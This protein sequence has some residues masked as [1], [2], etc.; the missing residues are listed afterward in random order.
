MRRQPVRIRPRLRT[1]RESGW[2][3]I[4]KMTSGKRIAVWDGWRGI[5][6]LLVLIGHFTFSSWIWEER[7]GVD[8]FFVLSG[9]L[10]SNILFVERM[11][12]SDFYIRRFSRVIPALV[13]FLLAAF[14]VSL[15]L[16]YDFK[17]S[18][19]LASLFFVRTY[20]PTDPEYF[21]TQLPTG[22]LWSLNVEEHAYIIMSLISIILISRAK[23]ALVLIAIYV[24]SVIVNFYNYVNLPALEF[25]YSLIR[26]ESAIGFI[27]FSA[28]YTLFRIKY[29]IQIHP[30]LPLLLFVL[31]LAC[32]MRAVPIWLTFLVSPV[33]LGIA[34]NHL[35][36]AAKSLQHLLMFKPLRWLGILSYSIYLWQQIFYKLYYAL[37]GGAFTGFVLSIVAGAG[38]FYIVE[39]PLRNA[40]NR[41]WSK[42]PSYRRKATA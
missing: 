42:A 1:S 13:V 33:F 15:L 5:A 11:H 25:E 30:Q 6:I 21:S 41:R 35:V 28:A 40:I 18:E 17:T 29:S 9:M 24:A 12:L 20:F 7:F 3:C 19:F 22:H 34:V 8:V 4:F 26:T 37:P 39:T 23:V 36:D 32:Y 14:A 10:M 2:T 27:A 38:S 16:Q 31:A